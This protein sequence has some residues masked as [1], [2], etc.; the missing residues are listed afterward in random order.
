MHVISIIASCRGDPDYGTIELGLLA[1]V[2]TLSARLGLADP[3][4]ELDHRPPTLERFG[5]E[6]LPDE[7]DL[8]AAHAEVAQ[9]VN[10]APGS[11]DELLE[12]QSPSSETWDDVAPRLHSG[13]EVFLAMSWYGS[14]NYHALILEWLDSMYMTVLQEPQTHANPI[15]PILSLPLLPLR[16]H[17][18]RGCAAYMLVPLHQAI[19]DSLSLQSSAGTPP[20]KLRQTIMFQKNQI[21]AIAKQNTNMKLELQSAAAPAQHIA[22]LLAYRGDSRVESLLLRLYQLP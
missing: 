5:A 15:L 7:D 8:R 12:E 19:R 4:P 2:Q 13:E 10:V 21:R 16:P 22:N 20:E 18:V 17:Q 3:F 9:Q 1:E 6:F 11:A 14:A